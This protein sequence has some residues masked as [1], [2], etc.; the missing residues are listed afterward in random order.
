MRIFETYRELSAAYAAGFRNLPEFGPAGFVCDDCGAVKPLPGTIHAGGI[1]S[2]YAVVDS[3]NGGRTRRMICY[4]CADARHRADLEARPARIC[5]YISGDE[6][7]FTT[8]TGGMLGRVV[9]RSSYRNNWRAR[10]YCYTVRDVFG[11]HWHGRNSG[12]GMCITL[13]PSKGG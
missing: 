13:R 6:S 7:R 3:D 2:G 12:G 4:E 10:V 1:E 11:R 5:G 9:S 8:W